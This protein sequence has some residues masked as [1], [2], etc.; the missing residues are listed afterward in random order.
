[1]ARLPSI[2]RRLRGPRGEELSTDVAWF[3][4]RDAGKVAILISAAHG[5]E[6]YCDPRRSSIGSLG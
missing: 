4:D 1:M 2:R 3:G 5:P 6:G